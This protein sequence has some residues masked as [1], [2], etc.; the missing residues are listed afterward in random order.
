MLGRMP[1]LAPA[2]T[3]GEVAVLVDYDNFYVGA[4][5][6]REGMTHEINRMISLAFSLRPETDLIQIRLYG[7]WLEN[8][9]LTNRGSELQAAVSQSVFPMSHPTGTG[10]VRGSAMLVTRLA[11][12]PEMEWKH[13]YRTGVGM[14]RLQLVETP[15][16]PGCARA[17]SCPID[18]VQ[19]MSRRRARECHIEG[20]AVRNDSAF[21]MREQKMV[22]SMICC[23]VLAFAGMGADV[24]VMSDDL[25]VLPAL[26][27]APR[28]GIGQICLVRSRSEVENLYAE[29]LAA[30]GVRAT[31]WEAA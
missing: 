22:D 30:L 14:P 23:D 7:G 25:D 15:R 16:P 9:L 13:T 5:E 28:T 24:V 11:L 6:S 17:D 29:E 10:V 2:I 1:P 31:A 3:T 18:L 19:R 20:C 12:V 26:A 8:G 21:R 4:V 27:M